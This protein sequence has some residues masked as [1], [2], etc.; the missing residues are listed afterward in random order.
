MDEQNTEEIQ[1]SIAEKVRIDSR[2]QAKLTPFDSLGSLL[3][4]PESEDLDTIVS[5]MIEDEK[6][7]DIKSINSSTDVPYLYSEIYMTGKYAEILSMAEA[8]DPIKI[9]VETVRKESN[10]YP[11]PTHTELFKEPIFK[12]NPDDLETYIDQVLKHDVFNDIKLIHASTG[13]RY[14]YSSLYMNKDHAIS[15]VEWNESQEYENP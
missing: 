14:L 9:I 8:N 1:I 10:I 15:L 5:E 4:D 13:A 7:K 3:Y 11:R 12:I 2:D 6:Y